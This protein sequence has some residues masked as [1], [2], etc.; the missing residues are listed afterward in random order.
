MGSRHSSKPS[1]RIGEVSKV[2]QVP[3]VT[4]VGKVP[5]VRQV[6]EVGKVPQVRQVTEVGEDTHY[7]KLLK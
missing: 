5:Q 3:Q 7:V 6:T 1:Y 2:P 4:E